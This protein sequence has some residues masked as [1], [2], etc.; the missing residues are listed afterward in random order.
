MSL[1][2]SLA[3]KLSTSE[4]EVTQFL[5]TA[6]RKYKV[7]T[8]PKR[9]KGVRIIAQPSKALKAYQRAFIDLYSLPAHPCSMAYQKGLGIKENAIAHVQNPF[10]LKMDFENF[11]N[12]IKPDMVLEAL[13]D[14]DC[15]TPIQELIYIKKLLFW[16]PSR[17][18]PNNLI[19]S[20][21]APSSPALSNLCMLAFDEKL[22]NLCA[23]QNITYTRY[24]DD[25]TFSTKQ[26]AI[27]FSIPL[28]VKKILSELFDKGIIINA[29]KTV[30]TSKAHNRHITGI[31]I[32]NENA[33]SLG[34]KRKRYIKHLVHQFTLKKL[35]EDDLLHL[36]G[37]LSFANH[38]EPTFIITLNSKYTFTV[39]RQIIEAR[40]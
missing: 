23:A 1:I 7:Y 10:F 26:K 6:P 9:T 28:E 24:A 18:K 33:L 32:N 19:L 29:D 11:F 36:Q 17:R 39:M 21:G 37:L 30:F 12:S 5:S 8:I 27:L 2:T 22:S 14:T 20:I 31:T 35:S 40:T 4:I 34:R 25:L 3:K 38:I 13:R 15:P 16:Q